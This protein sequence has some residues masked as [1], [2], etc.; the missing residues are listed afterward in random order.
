MD[1]I[2]QKKPIMI[3]IDTEL[4]IVDHSGVILKKYACGS[5]EATHTKCMKR[6]VAIRRNRRHI[7]RE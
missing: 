6:A 2:T 1:G 7:L 5:I 4:C 3:G